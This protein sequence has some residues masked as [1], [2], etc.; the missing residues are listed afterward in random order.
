MATRKQP[1]PPPIVDETVTL[2][3]ALI[4]LEPDPLVVEKDE[5]GYLWTRPSNGETTEERYTVADQ[6][7]NAAI[8]QQGA[9][10][11]FGK[12]GDT[13]VVVNQ[14]IPEN[15]TVAEVVVSA[16]GEV[17]IG[18]FLVPGSAD[19]GEGSIGAGVMPVAG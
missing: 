3:D 13:F 4:T 5:I 16:E 10:A 6:A 17:V 11:D 12:W 2:I 14:A 19:A 1:T 15:I 18:E 8:D 9:M 7:I